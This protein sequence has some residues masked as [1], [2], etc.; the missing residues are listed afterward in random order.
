MSMIR[1]LL[2]QAWG[3]SVNLGRRVEKVSFLLPAVI[4]LGVVISGA[5]V[6]YLLEREGQ[7]AFG[8]IWDGLWWAAVSATTTGYGDLVPHTAAGKV[9]AVVV[10][11]AGFG[12]VPV[13]TATAATIFVTRRL[14]EER[15][16]ERIAEKGHTVICGWSHDARKILQG[17]AAQ[18]S[19]RLSSLVLVNELSE[20]A[21]SEVLSAYPDLGLSKHG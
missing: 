7:P 21:M 14:K 12:L 11:L 13:V 9:I 15:G 1:S 19:D 10:I 6:V 2:G 3:W 16:L 8:S 5:T 4:V 17:L 18:R 20:A